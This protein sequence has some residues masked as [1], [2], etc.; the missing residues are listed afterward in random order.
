[1]PP[2]PGSGR[3]RCAARGR[4]V[5]GDLHLLT[6]PADEVLAR[7]PGALDETGTERNR[8]C[9]PRFASLGLR[10]WRDALPEDDPSDPRLKF[11]A[12]AGLESVT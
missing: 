9:Y 6:E 5:L 8:Q 11:F 2:A 10:L 3:S 7:V 12:G 4:F 1:M